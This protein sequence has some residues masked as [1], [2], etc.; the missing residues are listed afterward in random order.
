MKTPL[1]DKLDKLYE[2]YKKD[3]NKGL[4]TSGDIN[5]N[6]DYG[7]VAH[8]LVNFSYD[9]KWILKN[10]EL[11]LKFGGDVNLQGVN[12]GFSFIHLALYGYT[13]DQ[14]LD[15]SYDTAFIVALINLGKKYGL[16][17]NI[18]DNDS[19]SIVHAAI[20][21]EIYTGQIVPIM[22]ALGD[23][24]DFKVVDAYQRDIIKALDYYLEEALKEKNKV[25]AERLKGEKKKI[26]KFLLEFYS[27][28]LEHKKD[29]LKL[30]LKEALNVKNI[31]DL[32]EN[33][34]LIKSIIEELK[35]LNVEDKEYEMF[36]DSAK[37]LIKEAVQVSLKEP[38]KKDYLELKEL[39]QFFNLDMKQELAKIKK[40]YEDRFKKLCDLMDGA[41]TINSIVRAQTTE[42]EFLVTTE[43]EKTLLANKSKKLA[44]RLQE[45]NDLKS[46]INGAKIIRGQLIGW[47][48][49]YQEEVPEAFMDVVIEDTLKEG[50][51]N[52]L[53]ALN[54][55]NDNLKRRI[56]SLLQIKLG[57]VFAMI[58][59]N[60]VLNKKEFDSLIKD[61]YEEILGK[62]K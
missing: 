53:I 57:E 13:D 49:S 29:K 47:L 55:E 16:D 19:D 61:T 56:Y 43:D 33:L 9:Q 23:D 38:K 10:L 24:F 36:F 30:K 41:N 18:K 28:E 39:V 42:K 17:V 62:G 12:T 7:G 15:K 51:N 45:L 6:N 58:K 14:G 34:K 46:K 27:E 59:L 44:V 52:L 11:F 1:N 60:N 20:A 3:N 54:Q 26:E 31:G 4:I 35:G 50:L 22:E 5:E 32:F 48:K 8:A 37:E 21:S 40:A 2:C 25:W